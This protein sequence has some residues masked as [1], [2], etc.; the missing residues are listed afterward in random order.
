MK[1][2]KFDTTCK[3]Y[4]SY[5]EDRSQ[6]SKKFINGKKIYRGY[7]PPSKN[8]FISE[9]VL[10]DQKK[11]FCQRHQNYLR[12]L[13]LKFFIFQMRVSW[14]SY[15]PRGGGCTPHKSWGVFAY[16]LAKASSLNTLY[17]LETWYLQSSRHVKIIQTVS[18]ISDIF[19]VFMT[20]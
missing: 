8:F 5:L 7:T 14:F 12:R 11:I 4:F 3:K 16:I 2:F 6:K 18:G 13:C 20:S 19:D 1:N 10:Q 9:F 17:G 15:H